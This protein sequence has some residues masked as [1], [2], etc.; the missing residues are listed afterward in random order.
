MPSP[1]AGKAEAVGAR[2][3]DVD[4]EASTPRSSAIRARMAGAVRSDPRGLRD[5]DGVDVADPPASSRARAPARMHEK[6]GAVGALPGGVAVGEEL[7]EG[8]QRRRAEDRVGD[9]VEQRVAVGVARE[10]RRAPGS[11]IPPRRSAPRRVEGVRVEA[12]TDAAAHAD[13]PFPRRFRS[14]SASSRSS[15]VVIFRFQRE[16][17]TAVTITPRSSSRPASSVASRPVS[18]ARA[19]QVRA[20]RLRRPGRVEPLAVDRRHDALPFDALDGVDD[21]RRRRRGASGA[22]RVENAVDLRGGDERAR[23]VVDADEVLGRGAEGLE[24]P[25]HGGGAR[26]ASGDE[27]RPAPKNGRSKSGSRSGG[28]ATTVRSKPT[29]AEGLE[30]PGKDR[31]P[32]DRDEGLG[33]RALQ[34]RAR[35]RGRNDQERG[36]RPV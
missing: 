25:A 28:A 1:R 34:A 20:E 14:A 31:M 35:A 33:R 10:A 2:A 17:G 7:A 12:E 9:R 36:H 19:E 3:A 29:S 5:D 6:A 27:R 11:S 15:G 32:E 30:R 18:K 24:A 26:G 23:G 4:R 13:H 22:G 16:T 8:R 21:R